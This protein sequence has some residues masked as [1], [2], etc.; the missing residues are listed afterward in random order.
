MSSHTIHCT[1]SSFCLIC[2]GSS[3]LLVNYCYE[4]CISPSQCIFMNMLQI[5][6]SM[7]KSWEFDWDL[8]LYVST[9]ISPLSQSLCRWM[10]GNI[11]PRV[12]SWLQWL[13]M[14][15]DP[16]AQCEH[17][18]AVQKGLPA[19][20]FNTDQCKQPVL[21][22]SSRNWHSHC[23]N[24]DPLNTLHGWSINHSAALGTACC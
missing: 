20:V 17:R 5:Y 23:N 18:S 22:A 4:L 19:E 10:N 13:I 15:A 14:T 7:W 3:K 16:S 2:T 12:K 21:Y 8:I 24:T 9:S 11:E 6:S 1:T